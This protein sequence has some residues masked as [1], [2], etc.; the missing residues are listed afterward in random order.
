[1]TF[2]DD[3][4]IV[5]ANRVRKGGVGGF[6]AREYFEVIVEEPDATIDLRPAARL[7]RR[8]RD[9]AHEASQFVGG[10][11]SVPRSV[12][13]LVEERNAEERA[14]SFGVND[15]PMIGIAEYA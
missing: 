1:M 3:V 8:R 10:S 12:L 2:G 9:D 5:A 4:H 15:E 6:F 7:G 11:R 13:D 14:M